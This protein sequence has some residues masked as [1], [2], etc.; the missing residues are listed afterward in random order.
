MDADSFPPLAGLLHCLYGF[1]KR[2]SVKFYFCVCVCSF[3][4]LFPLLWSLDIRNNGLYTQ[5]NRKQDLKEI[6][7][8]LCS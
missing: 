5:K 3:F 8:H 2:S 6:V 7:T 4:L 1:F